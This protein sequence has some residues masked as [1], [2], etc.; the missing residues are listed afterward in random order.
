MVRTSA[1]SRP[2][3]AS[4]PPEHLPLSVAAE[5]ADEASVMAQYGRFLA[6][7]KQHPAFAGDRLT[8]E[9]G[10]VLVSSASS[11][12]NDR[13]LLQHVVRPGNGGKTGRNAGSADGTWVRGK[14]DG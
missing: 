5:A 4:V 3:V 11:A 7:R 12:R 8:L 13:L 10:P 2:A 6:F 1:A 9:D 14:R